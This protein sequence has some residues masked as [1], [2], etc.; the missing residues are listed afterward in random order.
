MVI[1]HL[2]SRPGPGLAIRLNTEIWNTAQNAFGEMRSFQIEMTEEDMA[3][4]LPQI[5]ALAEE[6]DRW[7]DGPTRAPG[8]AGPLRIKAAVITL[9]T[10]DD[11]N[12]ADKFIKEIKEYWEGDGAMVSSQDILND[13][14]GMILEVTSVKAVRYASDLIEEARSI[15]PTRVLISS[16]ATASSAATSS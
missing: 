15:S 12:K 2:S 3:N 16:T 1:L 5:E 6:W 10:G 9:P 13:L 4:K 14:T 11:S 7:A 8:S